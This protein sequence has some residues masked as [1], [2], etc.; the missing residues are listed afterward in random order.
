MGDATGAVADLGSQALP[1]SS[2]PRLGSIQDDP[3]PAPKNHAEGNGN[4]Y[5]KSLFPAAGG[6]GA[7]AGAPKGKRNSLLKGCSPPASTPRLKA[8]RSNFT[9]PQPFSLTT[10]KRATAA[11]SKPT[12]NGVPTPSKISQLVPQKSTPKKGDF[13]AHLAKTF[14][15]SP[16]P[17]S[18]GLT[19]KSKA[20]FVFRSD[21]RA[22][23][24]MEFYANL[25]EK[26]RAREAERN[27]IQA[28]TQQQVAAEIK[29][30]RKDQTFKATPMPKFY[31]EP[32][33]VRIDV[34]KTPPTRPKSPKLGR[35]GSGSSSTE[36]P[37]KIIARRSSDEYDVSKVP[38]QFVSPELTA[39][40][41][42]ANDA[43]E[44][45]S[46]HSSRKSDGTL[47]PKAALSEDEDHLVDATLIPKAALS[48]G[49]DH[50]DST[51]IPKA[52]LSEDGDHH[53]ATLIPKAALSGDEDHHHH[54][55]HHVA[56]DQEVHEVD[57][58]HHH[59]L[60]TSRSSNESP[61]SAVED[62]LDAAFQLPVSSS[63]LDDG[64]DDLQELGSED[65]DPDEEFPSPASDQNDREENVRVFISEEFRQAA[66]H[67]NDDDD[68]P[69][70]EEEE[71]EEE[72]DE[73]DGSG[74]KV[75]V[76]MDGM[77]AEKENEGRH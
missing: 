25:T 77:R 55:D 15:A 72:D 41:N 63:L 9:V 21:E 40:E 69:N 38:D 73:E 62:E 48:E 53:D 46:E 58:H 61:V 68:R 51:L 12:G 52:A 10:E 76:N 3:D 32:P 42:Y 39:P 16:S 11:G 57:D 30:L 56:Q 43:A 64:D 14:A 70:D 50:R 37:P 45:G 75:Y 4:G 33:P 1:D 47:V 65:D 22:Q 31:Q 18:L 19:P 17:D 36:A 35:R 71:E 49:E 74:A 24:R 13:A 66:A 2:E 67:E 44:V 60:E 29:K 59:L 20:E 54:Q 8:S 27:R 26:T 28:S 23:K 5:K 6:A 34:K 7:G